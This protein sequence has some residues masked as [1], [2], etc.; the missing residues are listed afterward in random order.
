MRL[1]AGVSQWNLNLALFVTSLIHG[2]YYESNNTHV[3]AI[4]WKQF[5][6]NPGAEMSRTPN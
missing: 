3:E 4:R 1:Q 2:R 5:Q 6:G